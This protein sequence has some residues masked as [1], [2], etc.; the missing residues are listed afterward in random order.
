MDFLARIAPPVV[1]QPQAFT[2]AMLDPVSRGLLGGLAT[3]HMSGSTLQA[4]IRYSADQ[5]QRT[6]QGQFVSLKVSN[7]SPCLYS[8]EGTIALTYQGSC[9]LTGAQWPESPK[10]MLWAPRFFAA[11]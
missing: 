1:S 7:H 3:D 10:K 11:A 5:L 6:V 8:Q 4:T 2:D 9:C